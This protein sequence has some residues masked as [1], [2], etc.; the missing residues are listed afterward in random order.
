MKN[1]KLKVVFVVVLII[2][3]AGIAGIFNKNK[4]NQEAAAVSA[5]DKMGVSFAPGE[6]HIIIGGKTLFK[7]NNVAMSPKYDAFIIDDQLDTDSR[8]AIVV[9]KGDPLSKNFKNNPKANANTPEIAK[10]KQE[11]ATL[12]STFKNKAE[13][14]LGKTFTAGKGKKK[15]FLRI[16]EHDLALNAIVIKDDTFEN[17]KSKLANLP[18][19]AS[20]SE[21]TVV[22]T[23]LFES[24]HQIGADDAWTH[25]VGNGTLPL[26]GSGMRVG[27]IDTGI[28]YT[29]PDLGRCFGSNCKVVGGWDYVNND[30]DPMD[31]HFHGTHVSS[32]IAGNGTLTSMDG[33]TTQPLP[34]VAPGA[35]IYS[36]K[37]LDAG[38][39]GF[40]SNV[41]LGIERCADPDG[42]G[43][44]VDHLDVCSMS[45]GGPG[46]PDD[47]TSQA[48]D[49]ATDLGVFFAIAAGNAGPNQNTIG[50]PGTARKALTVAA[51]C[52]TSQLA[53]G[54]CSSPIANFSSR[55]PVT[56][57]D[58]DGVVQ[59][60]QK[61]DITAPG[62][63]ICAAFP[64]FSSFPTFTA[65]GQGS[66]FMI[67]G[68]SM[69]TPHIAGVAAIVREA[70]PYLTPSE[71]KDALMSNATDL[72]QPKYAQGSGM[73]SVPKIFAT[74][75]YPSNSFFVEGL[76]AKIDDP[77]TSK[78]AV[79]TKLISVTNNTSQAYVSQVSYSKI[80]TPAG[81]SV[82]LKNNGNPITQL[83]F[84][85]GEK[86]TITIEASIDHT[87]ALTPSLVQG[88]VNI[89]TPTNPATFG[90]SINIAGKVKSN[91]AS[92]DF[93]TISPGQPASFTKTMV[94]TNSMSDAPVTVTVTPDCCKN[95]GVN[96]G[97]VSKIDG[98]T[99][100][101]I[102]FA[103][104]ESKTVVV[105]VTSPVIIGNTGQYSG[106]L[107]ITNATQNT[108]IP[109][110]F[111]RGYQV[112]L[113]YGVG[114][115]P[116]LVIVTD[117]DTGAQSTIN[118]FPPS[119]KLLVTKAGP[120]DFD[121]VFKNDVYVLHNSVT[122]PDSGLTL[123]TKVSDAIN[124]ITMTPTWADGSQYY[125][126]ASYMFTHRGF[127]TSFM[128]SSGNTTPS[129]VVKTNTVPTSTIFSAGLAKLD[130]IGMATYT[131]SGVDK[132]YTLSN[133]ATQIVKQKLVNH[134]SNLYQIVFHVGMPL[135]VHRKSFE[136]PNNMWLYGFQTPMV[137]SGN[138]IYTAPE[139]TL[140]FY[141]YQ[142]FA[143]SPATVDHQGNVWGLIY[144]YSN[145]DKNSNPY[146]ATPPF[147]YHAGTNM[148]YTQNLPLYNTT[149]GD[150]NPAKEWSY[151]GFDVIPPSRPMTFGLG[152]VFDAT[153]WGFGALEYYPN[154]ART[155][156]L[157]FS[158]GTVA[159]WNTFPNSSANY[160]F[161]RNNQIV[162]TGT[163]VSTFNPAESFIELVKGTDPELSVYDFALSGQYSIAGKIFPLT[164]NSHFVGPLKNS[165]GVLD[166][167]RTK[168][169]PA[170]KRI[171]FWSKNMPQEVIDPSQTNVL[172]FIIEPVSTW[173]SYL[174]GEIT[175]TMSSITAQ[176]SIDGGMW[177]NISL[178]NS[179]G[180]YSGTIPVTTA[181]KVYAFKING[182]DSTGATV[183]Y[184]F[185]LPF[186]VAYDG[187]TVPK[188]TTP[189]SVYLTQPA[190]NATVSGSV[191]VSA[192]ASD[193]S[194]VVSKVEF[195][196]GSNLLGASTNSPYMYTWDTTQVVN[197][198]YSLTAK[199]FDV[200]GN[201][202]TSSQIT[203][204]V[205]N[206]VPDT[207]NPTVSLTAPANNATV[208]G[209]VAVSANASDN[210]GVVSK[211]EFY[212]DTTTLIATDTTAP[213]STT[214][215]ST[216]VANGSH[217][218]SA[219]AYD[220]S[221][222]A[223]TS[224]VTVN[225]VNAAPSSPTVTITSPTSSTVPANGNVK[226]TATATSAQGISSI[227]LY[228][229]TVLKQT[230]TAVTT[231]SYTVNVKNLSVGNHVLSATAISTANLSTTVSKTVTK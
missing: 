66:H 216:A 2:V 170:L 174:N 10:R 211:V 193:D 188:D 138:P 67:S 4:N 74:L 78:N 212:R 131:L 87:L 92:I 178:T 62:V 157:R 22:K 91:V 46:N 29:H 42:N 163:L 115:A 198:S 71:V 129:L 124:S 156:P 64:L 98:Q 30:A 35:K 54:T 63:K 200:S 168:T 179:G 126:E 225:V 120:W 127:G 195:Y 213:Y 75:G 164:T 218:I 57:T 59:T 6:P 15:G 231:C 32:T 112:V 207:A 21:N 222:N 155:G 147:Y 18:E 171:Q 224:T 81:V 41:I 143:D 226:F 69:A 34:G 142:N 31:D 17:I 210:S 38:G 25:Y 76:P 173:T 125:G 9:L 189:P 20:I 1:N 93:G 27:V 70:F 136:A 97:Y 90:V 116:Y 208:S 190:N 48:I 7:S 33:K 107:S 182:I 214:W 113:D 186:G 228:V 150:I 191:T 133:T 144:A 165:Y 51:G 61:P 137:S 5:F 205:S 85:P 108:S 52:K 220:P 45:L 154:Q 217:T 68:T 104:G 16:E 215:N 145:D 99:S 88:T 109:M 162:K 159:Y 146:V 60:L 3:I 40:T 55:G 117:L 72:V 83:S 43:N 118:T 105:T 134:L 94:L 199:A 73:V 158:D 148:T 181:G 47:A 166:T 19:V 121:A 80:G 13:K 169:P 11:I 26:D 96:P 106:S 175:E 95:G 23:D 160:T 194:G 58:K 227:K 201:S 8:G 184:N 89:T 229:D 132:S 167:A 102:T 65:C 180:E 135:Q 176:V 153:R 183:E 177:Q 84:A 82:V 100:E 110:S 103:P 149:I 204:T 172:K 221:N 230:C 12:H 192:N 114:E 209:S 161:N 151:Y 203:V 123:S 28:D 140:E 44:P 56:W 122:I 139:F 77:V 101:T 111:F 141:N 223:S 24:V 219:K 86:K 14:A 197:G 50:S 206:A 39:G 152:P 187:G 202:A 119:T 49:N 37:V 53:D 79:L 36:Y 196:Q 185:G 130:G 128:V